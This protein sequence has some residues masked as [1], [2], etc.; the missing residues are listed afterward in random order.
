MLAQR[1]ATIFRHAD[2]SKAV[3]RY[4]RQNAE[5]VSLYAGAARQGDRIEKILLSSPVE[6]EADESLARANRKS[7]LLNSLPVLLLPDADLEA[8]ANHR[9]LTLSK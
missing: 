8:K 4:P 1:A 2:R 6:V 7:G 9:A 3:F 5:E